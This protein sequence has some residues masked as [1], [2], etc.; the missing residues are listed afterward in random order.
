MLCLM[1]KTKTTYYIYTLFTLP[2]LLVGWMID[3]Y[4]GRATPRDFYNVVVTLLFDHKYREQ[5][6]QEDLTLCEQGFY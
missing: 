5:C 1:V 6:R 4:V 3:A 2:L